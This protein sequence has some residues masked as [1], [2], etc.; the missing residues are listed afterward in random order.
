MKHAIIAMTLA[1]LLTGCVTAAPTSLDQKLAGKTDKESRTILG[2]ACYREA[3]WPTYN[4]IEYKNS[5]ARRRGQMKNNPG[6]EV[7]D[8]L[9]LC[10]DMR[11][12]TPE[13]AKALA[14]E[15]G[16]LLAQKSRRYGVKAEGHIQR[17]KDLCERMTRE[18]VS[19][20]I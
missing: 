20:P 5:G 16:E 10:R 12:S 8:M 15:C 11:K 6:P 1:A 14:T 4:S 9:A 13:N 19:P 7:R 2:Y 18:S 17:T 3:E